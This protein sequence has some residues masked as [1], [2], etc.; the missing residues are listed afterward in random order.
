MGAAAVIGSAMDNLGAEVLQER[1]CSGPLP[2]LG[3]DHS[4][5]FEG[6]LDPPRRCS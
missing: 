4:E 6:T 2:N 3:V 5:G 1:G